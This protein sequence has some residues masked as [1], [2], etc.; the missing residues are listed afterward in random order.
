MTAALD[1]YDS[2]GATLGGD[3]A[4]RRLIDRLIALPAVRD[5]EWIAEDQ[6]RIV[7]EGGQYEIVSLEENPRAGERTTPEQM[8]AFLEAQAEVLRSS[9]RR[10]ETLLCG[11]TYLLAISHMGPAAFRARLDAIVDSAEPEALKIA[12]LQAHTGHRDA[13]ADLLF[14]RTR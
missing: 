7:R 1:A 6:V 4:A 2:E 12:R 14:A 13:A 5:A 8:Q 10:N 9:L 11:A 3:E